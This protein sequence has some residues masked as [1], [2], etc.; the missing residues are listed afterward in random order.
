MHFFHNRPRLPAVI[1]YRFRKSNVNEFRKYMTRP[2]ATTD[3]T[4]NY[5]RVMVEE[6]VNRDAYYQARKRGESGNE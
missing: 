4:G 3:R 5:H 1:F 2:G 6:H